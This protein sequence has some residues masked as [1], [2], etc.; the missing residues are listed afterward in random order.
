MRI[1]VTGMNGQLGREL[2]AANWPTGT[3]L[4][5]FDRDA[6][7][8]GD[9]QTVAARVAK[10]APDVVVNAAAYTAVDRAEDEPEAAYRVNRDGPAALAPAC[11]DVGAAL[12]QV[13]TDYVF[14]G[15][16]DSPWTP[17]DP[18]RPL[19]TYGASKAAGEDAVRT[20]L[21]RHVILRTAWV[22][23]AHGHNFV[24]TMLKHGAQ[25]DHLKVV[26]DQFSG[27]TAADDI[28]AALV[29]IADQI[30][31]GREHWGTYHFC[32][33]PTA[34]WYDFAQAIFDRAQP[35]WGRRPEVTRITSAEW[36]TPVSRPANSALDCTSLKTDYG[37]EQPDW[38]ARLTAIVARLVASH[39]G[40]V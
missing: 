18:V 20:S 11:A 38:R 35:V 15:T 14:D 17:H 37:I 7:D 23:A 33:A 13:S 22:H 30:A 4:L 25:K 31:E 10:L 26:G 28:A 29:V 3:E 34:S 9:V 8:L 40:K 2:R 12:L 24:R 6:L 19:G 27:P 5:A 32:G 36:P 1:L 16:K 21:D 39:E